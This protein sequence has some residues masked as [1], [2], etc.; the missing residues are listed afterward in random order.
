MVVLY[1]YNPDLITV[2]V[3]PTY[4]IVDEPIQQPMVE[5]PI[6]WLD[7]LIKCLRDEKIPS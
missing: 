1:P 3:I 5:Q 7:L 4:T 2:E 6:D